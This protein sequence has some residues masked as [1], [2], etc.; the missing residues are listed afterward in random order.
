MPCKKV[1]NQSIG[2]IPFAPPA[3]QR[4]LPQICGSGKK[5]AS[6]KVSDINNH[7]LMFFMFV[8]FLI[9]SNLFAKVTTYSFVDSTSIKRVSIRSMC[10]LTALNSSASSLTIS[11]PPVR[12]SSHSSSKGSLLA[13]ASAF[14]WA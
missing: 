4:S 5:G 2:F 12:N 10:S 9:S 13:S 1:S 11:S 6:P 3:I 7:N 14:L 8:L